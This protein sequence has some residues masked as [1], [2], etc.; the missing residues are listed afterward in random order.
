MHVCFGKIITDF[1]IFENRIHVSIF[2][3]F[4]YLFIFSFL[5]Y[6][7]LI[8]F[9]IYFVFNNILKAIWKSLCNDLLA[10]QWGGA[11]G[12]GGF[13]ITNR[14]LL[15]GVDFE[16]KIWQGGGGA[17]EMTGF[18]KNCSPLPARHLPSWSPFHEAVYG[19]TNS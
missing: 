17:E 5:D 11:M 2:Y 16:I 15:G 18:P 7:C 8:F 1:A 10:Q 9:F 3:L 19:R 6:H 14:L 13:S 4:I 12:G